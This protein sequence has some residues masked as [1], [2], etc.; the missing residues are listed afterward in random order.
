MILPIE[1]TISKHVDTIKHILGLREYAKYFKNDAIANKVVDITDKMID[2][3][4]KMIAE[5][6]K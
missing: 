3:Y 5:Y 1:D 4:D 2:T 6:Y